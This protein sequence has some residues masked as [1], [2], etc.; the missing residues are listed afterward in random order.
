[1]LWGL[2]TKDYLNFQFI[3]FPENILMADSYKYLDQNLNF[4]LIFMERVSVLFVTIKQIQ[5]SVLS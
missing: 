1:M 3:H 4:P 2:A 5:L